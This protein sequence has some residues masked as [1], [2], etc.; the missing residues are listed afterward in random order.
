M[1]WPNLFIDLYFRMM[2]NMFFFLFDLRDKLKM[3]THDS[4]SKPLG[5]YVILFEKRNKWKLK[6]HDSNSK[7]CKERG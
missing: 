2:V 7:P 3:K 4:N 6:T 1:I 5:N